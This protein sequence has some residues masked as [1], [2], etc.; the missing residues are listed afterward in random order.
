MYINL[1]P[2]R[3]VIR[4]EGMDEIIVE[5]SGTIARVQMDEMNAGTVD[6][7]PIIRRTAGAVQ[8]LPAR[9]DHVSLLVSGMV[10]G[11]VPSDRKDVLAPDTG[12][13]AVRDDKGHI[14]A[15][16]RLVSN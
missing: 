5:P 14:V 3:I 6:G 10:L 7:A 11:A 8:N 4:P 1:T 13:T 9:K 15:V 2:H 12:S 16:T